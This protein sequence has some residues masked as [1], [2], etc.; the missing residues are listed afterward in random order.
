M[1]YFYLKFMCK[2]L[3]G[4][5]TKALHIFYGEGLFYCISKIINIIHFMT[6]TVIFITIVDCLVVATMMPVHMSIFVLYQK[7]IPKECLSGV[8]SIRKMLSLILIP[9]GNMVFEV[10]TDKLPMEICFL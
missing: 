5:L 3:I 4:I 8:L 2:Y 6:L 9:F 1:I 10:F 7:T